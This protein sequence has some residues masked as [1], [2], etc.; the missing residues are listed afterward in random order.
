MKSF[1]FAVMFCAIG[2]GCALVYCRGM[3]HNISHEAV[4]KEGTTKELTKQLYEQDLEVSALVTDKGINFSIWNNTQDKYMNQYQDKYTAKMHVVLVN[5]LNT[6]TDVVMVGESWGIKGNI[7][8]DGLK[9]YLGNGKF[10]IVYSY[11]IC[12]K[13]GNVLFSGSVRSNTFEVPI[14]GDNG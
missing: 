9:E 12:R 2:F 6:Y 3:H 5:N 14:V 10:F 7:E 13:N 1:L 8:L 4:C 11:E